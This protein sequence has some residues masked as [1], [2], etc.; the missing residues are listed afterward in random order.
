MKTQRLALLGISLSLVL[1]VLFLG[2]QAAPRQAPSDPKAEVADPDPTRFAKAIDEFERWDAKNAW[3]EK[4]VLFVGSSSIRM[5][6]T[7]EAFPRLAVVNRGFGGSHIS[8]VNHYFD[9]V[10]K[11]YHARVILLYAGDND[12]ADNKGAEQVLEDYRE[13]VRKVR[14]LDADT[15]VIYIPIKPSLARWNLWPTMREANELIRK[16]SEADEKLYFVDVATPLL[17]A[18]GKPRKELLLD[19]GLHLNEAGYKMWTEIVGPV[20][21]KA[22]KNS[23]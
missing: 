16:M 20:I 1:A 5:W 21:E 7:R 9:Q 19:D 2:G 10:V 17:G 18:D 23:E 22:M 11:P 15:P 3:P 6:K 14:E 13:F 4:P 12:V 8:D